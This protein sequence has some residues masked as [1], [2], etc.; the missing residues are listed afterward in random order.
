MWRGRLHPVNHPYAQYIEAKA[1]EYF[2]RQAHEPHCE[3]LQPYKPCTD[4]TGFVY[5]VYIIQH[6]DCWLSENFEN[7]TLARKLDAMRALSH[8]FGLH[9]AACS[10]LKTKPITYRDK[11]EILRFA[12]DCWLSVD[13]RPE[14]PVEYLHQP[15]EQRKDHTMTKP[16]ILKD[17]T[18]AKSRAAA[19]NA[20]Q[21]DIN[22]FLAPFVRKYADLMIELNPNYD[23]RD[24]QAD[25][26]VEIDNNSFY[27]TGEEIYQ[28]SE[29]YTPSLNL[30]FAF[31]E[32]PETYRQIALAEKAAAYEK[33]VTKKKAEAA[34]RV[35][36]LKAQLARAEAEAS[37]A[38]VQKDEIKLTANR[39]RAKELRSQYM[40]QG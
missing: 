13:M 24:L 38:E 27:L 35:T 33:A 1:E 2:S 3:T 8:R 19:F 16:Q 6:C 7:L 36:R 22:D 37:A 28:Y 30:P 31:V 29:Y 5:D 21:N 10:R 17:L 32:D 18:I 20:A 4:S 15:E 25:S 12:C 26:F 9:S 39:N 34:E 23:Q 11:P 40:E 14:P